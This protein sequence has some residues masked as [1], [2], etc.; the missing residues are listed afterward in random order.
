MCIRD[1]SKS[2]NNSSASS[3]RLETGLLPRA[4][5]GL[6]LK[7]SSLR[8]LFPRNPVEPASKF[9]FDLKKYNP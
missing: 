9:I 8:M 5:V 4:I 7:P 3:G 1:R 6:L 2:I